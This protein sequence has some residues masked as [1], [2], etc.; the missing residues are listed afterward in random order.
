MP[1]WLDDN[2]IVGEL[3]NDDF[4]KQVMESMSERVEKE[5]KEGNY[6]NDGLLTVYQENKQH[7]GVSYK[8]I[9]LRYFAVT[10]LPRGHFQLQLGRGM[11]K[12][13]KHVVVEHDW[14]S[15]SYELKELLGLSEFLYHDSLHSGQEDWT[16]RQQWEKMDNWAIADCERV[17]SLVSEFDEKVKVLRQD[18]LSFIGACKQRPKAER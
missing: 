5:G 18:I 16:L 6:G 1:T 15:L 14:P 11:N 9:V 4:I 17:S 3:S 13:G 7:A 2:T 8:L 12:V 10:R